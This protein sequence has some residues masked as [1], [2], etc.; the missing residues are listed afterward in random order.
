MMT[1]PSARH[2]YVQAEVSTAL[3][4]QIRNLRM[5]RGWT[6]RELA[7]RMG[8]SQAVVSR[9]EDP[10]YARPTLQTLLQLSQVFDT[11]LQ[12]RF[13]STV[14]MLRDTWQPQPGADLVPTFA[15]EAP[16]I[17]FVGPASAQVAHYTLTVMVSPRATMIASPSAA[18]AGIATQ[19]L[20]PDL[21][22]AKLV[23]QR[24]EVPFNG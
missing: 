9:L 24:I 23:S 12:V 16:G 18:V 2:A 20:R 7:R 15:D 10:S 8:T 11:G 4:H 3:A 19:W 14:R 1:R 17:G 13:V 22:P 5:Q 6:Q 21:L